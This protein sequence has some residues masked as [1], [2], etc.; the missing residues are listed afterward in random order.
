MDELA[1]KLDDIATYRIGDD[2]YGLSVHELDARI[3]AYTSEIERLRGE[4]DKKNREKH[5]A[6]ALFSKKQC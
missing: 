3:L 2:L 4:L 6:D 5:A 1:P